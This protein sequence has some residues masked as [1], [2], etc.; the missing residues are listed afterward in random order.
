MLTGQQLDRATSYIVTECDSHRRCVRLK[1]KLWVLV[2]V[3]SL[4]KWLAQKVGA[5]LVL[6][7]CICVVCLSCAI[8]LK[9]RLGQRQGASPSLHRAGPEVTPSMEQERDH[10]C[11]V[12]N[13]PAAHR[14]TWVRYLFENCLL[15]A[16]Q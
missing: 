7:C 11:N 2:Y 15:F 10:V 12:W 9:L 14:M 1:R 5:V 8:K 3:G 6:C 16:H 13:S 4:C